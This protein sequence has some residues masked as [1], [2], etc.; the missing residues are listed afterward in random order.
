MIDFRIERLV[1]LFL[2]NDKNGYA[3]AKAIEAALNA[4]NAVVQQGVDCVMDYD[5]MPEWRLDEL[6]W[7]SNCLYDYSAPVETKREWIKNAI[8]L[9]QIYGTLESIRHFLSGYF[10]GVDVEEAPIYNG[11]P[12]HFRVTVDGEWTDAKEAWARRAIAQAKNVRSVLDELRLGTRCNVAIMAEGAVLARFP[13]PFTSTGL[14]TGTIPDVNTRGVIDTAPKLGAGGKAK[15]YAIPY[16]LSGTK[17]DIATYGMIDETPKAATKGESAAHP[18]GYPMTS[19]AIKAG[20][21]PNVNT[22]GKVV[23]AKAGASGQAEAH[24]IPYT[25]T[26]TVPDAATRGYVEIEINGAQA[27]D[28][29]GRIIYKMCGVDQI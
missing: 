27:A 22:I 8:P 2:F 20:T 4:M 16:P 29:I 28:V 7:E 17:P 24:R 21:K 15:G 5:T 12:Y 23:E 19:D 18:F 10:D 9:Y 13:Y 6:A 26:G 11:E 3:V 25:L 14:Y 1:P